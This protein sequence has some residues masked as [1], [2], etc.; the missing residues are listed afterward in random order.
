MGW[1]LQPDGNRID[2]DDDD[3]S[4]CCS[5]SSTLP[6]IPAGSMLVI[7]EQTLLAPYP[8]R[9]QNG[10]CQISRALTAV[11]EPSRSCLSSN[12]EH[13]PRPHDN[14]V[15]KQIP[16]AWDG[17]QDTRARRKFGFCQNRSF[18]SKKASAEDGMDVGEMVSG[19]SAT[20]LGEKKQG[21]Q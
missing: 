9:Q 8:K 14:N 6:S 7:S 11:V 5:S 21:L 19:L 2:D 1:I 17:C 16:M 15:A 12:V 18:Y 13:D 20:I 4:S 10:R 3:E